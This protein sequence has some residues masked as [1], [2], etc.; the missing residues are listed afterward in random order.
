MNSIVQHILL[1]LQISLTSG[2][3]FCWIVY[4]I[5]LNEHDLPGKKYSGCG[6]MTCVVTYIV[7][8]IAFHVKLLSVFMSKF[9]FRAISIAASAVFIAGLASAIIGGMYIPEMLFLSEILLSSSG[10]LLYVMQFS[11]YDSFKYHA[12]I[13]SVGFATSTLLFQVVNVMSYFWIQLVI[14]MVLVLTTT[15]FYNPVYDHLSNHQST[16][17]VLKEAFGHK[18]LY[19]LYTN[20]LFSMSFKCYY[21]NSYYQRLQRLNIDPPTMSLIF[22]L[23]GFSS[24][25]AGFLN[26]NLNVA[27]VLFSAMTISFA[28]MVLIIENQVTISVNLFLMNI[29]STGIITSALSICGETNFEASSFVYFAMLVGDM[30]GFV[31]YSRTSDQVLASISAVMHICVCVYLVINSK[32]K[33]QRGYQAIEQ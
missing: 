18:Q 3:I 8:S 21:T 1:F 11:L 9:S 30:V 4:E 13:V 19:A 20:A 7:S 25:A 16:L 12:V 15:L 33:S 14:W 23:S 24:V 26:V 10:A 32:K 22:S 6:F 17:Q 31:P 2:C 28:V 29:S 5:F 27:H